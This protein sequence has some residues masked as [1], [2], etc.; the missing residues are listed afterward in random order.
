MNITTNTAKP[1][2][3]PALLFFT[4]FSL[5]GNMLAANSSSGIQSHLSH[6]TTENY[7][8][9]DSNGNELASSSTQWN[10]VRD[11]KTG[12][13][14][15]VRQESGMHHKKAAYTW[16]ESQQFAQRVNEKG[17]C[18]SSDWRLPSKDELLS[19]VDKQRNS[20]KINTN[21]FPNTQNGFYWS[22]SPYEQ[23]ENGAW[24]VYFNLGSEFAGNKKIIYH[25][26][27]VRSDK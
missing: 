10:C 26:R 16:K 19:I 27:M 2:I 13:V 20:P 25:A 8:K 17:L 4:S 9:L 23:H 24:L 7:T 22:S 15:E 18:G 6:I 14:W 11:N 12:L 1:F 5:A 21:Y 3:F